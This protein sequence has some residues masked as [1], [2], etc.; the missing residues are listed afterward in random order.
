MTTEELRLAYFHC[1]QDVIMERLQ[2]TQLPEAL[3]DED[4][5]GL[6]NAYLEIVSE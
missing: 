6:A 3:T 1:L 5:I 4:R 2:V